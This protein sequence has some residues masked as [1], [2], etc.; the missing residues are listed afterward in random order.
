MHWM[1]QMHFVLFGSFKL[2]NST[3]WQLCCCY[4]CRQ[5][6][7]KAQS[8]MVGSEFVL[9]CCILF[10]S[11]IVS[12]YCKKKPFPFSPFQ[13]LFSSPFCLLVTSLIRIAMPIFL[14]S[15]NLPVCLTTALHLLSRCFSYVQVGMTKT[16]NF[17]SHHFQLYTNY[18]HYL[19]NFLQVP[20][21]E[22][23]SLE[24]SQYA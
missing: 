1:L 9:T 18:I 15:C 20:L 16:H 12:F 10:S 23:M 11:D 21:T 7:G 2:V 3:N 17:L 22:S 24:L 14:K 6:L 8:W 4:R 19:Y 5:A 13:S